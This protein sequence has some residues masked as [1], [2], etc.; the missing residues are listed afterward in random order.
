[1]ESLVSFLAA[2]NTLTPLAVIGLLGLAIFFIVWKNPFKPLESSLSEVKNNHLHELPAMAES[3]RDI[4]ATLQ[5]MEVKM[6]EDFAHLKARI[7]GNGHN[8]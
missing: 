2:L 6:G 4:S 8:R 5:R 1:M 3:L 7:N